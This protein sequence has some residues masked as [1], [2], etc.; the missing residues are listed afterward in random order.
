MMKQHTGGPRHTIAF[1][2]SYTPSVFLDSLAEKL[3]TFLEVESYCDSASKV[4]LPDQSFP[5]LLVAPDVHLMAVRWRYILR[6]L[7]GMRLN[8]T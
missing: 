6:F 2:L 4:G 5:L 1:A 3:Y 7:L 8:Q